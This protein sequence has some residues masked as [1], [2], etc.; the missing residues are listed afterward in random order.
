NDERAGRSADLEAAATQGGN[1]KAADD[2][3]V[4]PALRRDARSHRD[5]H[6]QRQRNDGDGEPRDHVAAE[7]GKPVSLCLDR[8]DLGTKKMR[9]GRAVRHGAEPERGG[10]SGEWLSFTP[11]SSTPAICQIDL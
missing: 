7:C 4:E 6:R 2:G 9:S 3:R 1:E 10:Y 5:R 8:Q 11:E